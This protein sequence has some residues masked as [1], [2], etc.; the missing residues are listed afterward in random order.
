MRTLQDIRTEL[1]SVNAA[2]NTINTGGQ[3]VSIGDMSYTYANLNALIEQ[4]NM[5]EKEE[6]RSAGTKRRMLKVN[7]SGMCR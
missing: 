3:S 4:R 1:S 6:A 5:L 7:F 2:I